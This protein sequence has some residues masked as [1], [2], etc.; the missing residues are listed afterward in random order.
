MSQDQNQNNEWQVTHYSPSASLSCDLLAALVGVGGREWS[1]A[2]RPF[3][4]RGSH[5]LCVG[6][7]LLDRL[8]RVGTDTHIYTQAKGTAS[9]KWQQQYSI[10][11]MNNDHK[12]PLISSEKVLWKNQP[13]P[14]RAC[15]I[16]THVQKLFKLPQA[17]KSPKSRG[18]LKIAL[19]ILF[20]LARSCKNR[21]YHWIFKFSTVI[22]QIM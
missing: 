13:P 3:V 18:R 19:I 16:K 20:L 12:L 17:K 21:N 5:I 9:W 15:P 10:G 22:A 8:M 4:L 7:S 11:G 1:S 14:P 2:K 6:H